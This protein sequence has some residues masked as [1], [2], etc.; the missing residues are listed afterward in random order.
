[1]RLTPFSKQMVLQ[2]ALITVAPIAPLL[3]TMVPLD[4]LL[5]RLLEVLI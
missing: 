1:M 5:S 2:L 4:E 3:L